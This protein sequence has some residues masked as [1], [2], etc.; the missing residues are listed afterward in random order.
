MCGIFGFVNYG[1]SLSGVQTKALYTTLAKSCIVRGAHAAGIAYVR[2]GTLHM[3]K[4]ASDLLSA[5]F[6]FPHNTMT[7]AAHCRLSLKK[8]Y[9]N[10]KNNHPFE[11]RT[12]DGAKYAIEHNGILAGL[13]ELRKLHGI[14]KPD[15]GTDSYFIAQL[16]DTKPTLTTETLKEVCEALRGSFSFVI[17]DEKNDLYICRGD[18]PIYLVHFKRRRLYLYASTRD[19]FESAAAETDLWYEYKSSNLEVAASTVNIVP[20]C[21]GDILRLS[22]KGETAWAS[23]SFHEASAIHHNWYM[24]EITET[25]A[26]KAQLENLNNE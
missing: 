15:I 3:Q 19:I 25:E 6:D 13:R 24:H 21:K 14:E 2:S 12:L 16:L 23:F 9:I 17:L 10:N 22:P 18:V 4:E 7:L 20:L 11:G 26:L 5:D 1:D 8:D